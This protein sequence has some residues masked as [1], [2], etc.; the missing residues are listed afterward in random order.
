MRD[1]EDPTTFDDGTYEGLSPRDQDRFEEE[2]DDKL[3]EFSEDAIEMELRS[4]YDHQKEHLDLLKAACAAFHPEDGAAKSDSDFKLVGVNPLAGTRQTPVDVAAIR[5]EYNC[6][7]VLLICCEIGGERRDEWVENVNS[8]HRYFDSQE[9][10]QQ[11]KEKLEINTRELDIGYI[12][13]TREDDT[14]GMDFSILDRNCD[15]SPYA[16]WEC[17]TGDKW[18]R[19]VEGS[20]VHSDLRDAF[21]DE[22]DY[23][24]REDPLDYAVG[25]HSVFPLE[26]IV[27]RIVKENTE[28]NA[29]DED[30]FDH[31]TFVEHYN[32]GL[33]VFCR[34]EN[35]DSLIENQTEAILHD[36]LAANILTDDHND[37]NTDKDYR[38]VYSGSRGPRH[39]RSA[40]KRR[41][42]E[43][44]PAYEKGRRAFDLTKDKFEP[45]TNLG[46]YQ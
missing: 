37:L 20:F 27:Y 29:D 9:T 23:S 36:G 8:V 43:N 14:T 42:F 2:F 25:S 6:V 12:S 38:V 13:L 33:Q 31:S 19:H 3:G 16:V 41:F 34:Q 5:P 30:E 1:V 21:Q 45:E 26:E 7:Y 15:V 35:R 11:I 28:F 22:I 40:V 32:D 4:E 46:D 44:M 17:E 18:L 10:R 39:A 24:R